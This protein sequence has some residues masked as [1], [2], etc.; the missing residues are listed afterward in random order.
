MHATK[1]GGASLRDS[2][3]FRVR[4][5]SNAWEYAYDEFALFTVDCDGIPRLEVWILGYRSFCL[6]FLSLF[7]VTSRALRET[8]QL[9]LCLSRM[10]THAD[11]H[12]HHTYS[13]ACACL[14]RAQPSA[15]TL[16]LTLLMLVCLNVCVWHMPAAVHFGGSMADQRI[17]SASPV[18]SC[19]PS[20]HQSLSLNFDTACVWVIAGAP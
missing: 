3:S 7:C 4:D 19:M 8:T 12:L 14:S 1:D 18:F 13:P 10:L 15:Y 20:P 2:D 5:T 6:E 16:L 17:S 9:F 11:T